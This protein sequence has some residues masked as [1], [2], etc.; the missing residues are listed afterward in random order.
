MERNRSQ[1]RFSLSMR[2][3]LHV[4]AFAFVVSAG[5][6]SGCGRTFFTPEPC[7]LD[8]Q[9]DDQNDCTLDRCGPDGVCRHEPADRDQDGYGAQCGGGD[10]CRDDLGSVHPGATEDCANG[11]DDNC[12]GATDCDDEHCAVAPECTSRERDCTNGR[13]DDNDGLTDCADAD[14][15]MD[16]ACQNPSEVCDNGWDDDGDGLIDCDD[17]DCSWD[18]ACHIP[19]EICDNGWDDDGDGLIDCDDPDCRDSVHCGGE[20]CTLVTDL[21]CGGEIT[22]TTD[23]GDLS[24]AIE[25]YSCSSRSEPG[26]EYAIVFVPDVTS[27]NG[28]TLVTVRLAP[29]GGDLDLFVLQSSPFGVACD[30]GSCIVA[31]AHAGDEA[32]SVTFTAQVGGEYVLVVD[33]P[34]PSGAWFDLAVECQTTCIPEPERCD[35]G[36]DDDCDSLIDCS[37]PDCRFAP[38]CQTGPEICDNGRDDDGDG[39]IDCDD[40]DCRFAPNCQTGPEICDNGRDDDGDGLIDCDDPDCRFAPNCQTGTCSP[41]YELTCGMGVS[42][43]NDGPG[44][45]AS[46]RHYG[47]TQFE[48]PAPEMSFLFQAPASGRIQVSL[49]G[50]SADLD[51]YVLPESPEGTCDISQCLAYSVAGGS[52]PESAT[53]VAQAG[54]SYYIVVDGFMDARS[55]FELMVDCATGS[56]ICDNGRDDD[57]DGLADCDDPDCRFA[58]NCQTG[59]EICDNGRDDD[60]DGLIDC[61]DPDCFGAPGCCIP[62][63]EDCTDHL[64]ND[65]DCLMD[66]SD[67][68]CAS[69]PYCQCSQE[70]CDDGQ[71]NDCDGLIDCDDP[72]CADDPN[73]GA[74]CTPEICTDLVDNDCDGLTDC[75]DPDCAS[76]PVCNTCIPEPEICDDWWDND[77]DNLVD[78]DD[79]D[80]NLDPA[81][82]TCVPEVCYNT[83]DDDCDGL[84]DCSDPDCENTQW[85]NL[86]CLPFELCAD[87]RDDDCDGLID[88]EDPDCFGDPYCQS[89]V[90]E[91]CANNLDDDCDSRIDCQDPDCANDPACGGTGGCEPVRPIGCGDQDWNWNDAPG[92]TRNLEE[93]SC[94]IGYETGPEFTYL[95]EA[96]QTGTVIVRLT[97]LSADLDLFV[98]EDVGA[99]TP[100]ACLAQ[101]I[102]GGTSDE[103]IRFQAEAG[104]VYFIVVDGY[105][106]S[107]SDYNLSVRC[108][109]GTPAPVTLE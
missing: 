72:S 47:C 42:T 6:L 83:R 46:I 81:C 24:R 73:C 90:P 22:D 16:P 67:P 62:E 65:C 33:S 52:S 7:S 87:L 1:G 68:D 54:R 30:A 95:F 37:D 28:Q 100:D 2:G 4:V 8:E 12:D 93:Y 58:P 102:A 98:L 84:I 56:E 18:P 86:P 74:P 3:C 106:G 40:P 92:S 104:H 45:V 55:D 11:I 15:A 38:N 29:Y 66:C 36:R 99:C 85:C 82:R 79:P 71:D 69:E 25:R 20:S 34:S 80:C 51:L 32:E 35:N 23:R 48:Y 50:L 61:D 5:I 14:C 64:D 21:V 63:P 10:D 43:R 70:V 60:G 78:C 105:A 96:T 108:R 94:G 76:S 13:D 57:S 27:P 41:V 75:D 59:P 49:T 19:S 39:L 53:F 26:R 44:S 97:G 31:S 88:C 103:R 101:S 107:V 77:C 109:G 89:C 91:R 9:C 17:P